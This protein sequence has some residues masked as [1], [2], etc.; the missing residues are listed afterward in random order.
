MRLDQHA[1]NAWRLWHRAQSAA[2]A[3]DD[4]SDAIHIDDAATRINLVN[5][6]GQLANHQSI[7]LLKISRNI[8]CRQGA[9][10]RQNSQRL[11]SGEMEIIQI[12]NSV[13]F[14]FGKPAYL[15]VLDD[16]KNPV[17]GISY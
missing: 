10:R 13:N 8:P 5:K 1:A 7:S 2:R 16:A 15:A 6:A 12:A 11:P 3:S 14:K 4:I 17:P 9:H